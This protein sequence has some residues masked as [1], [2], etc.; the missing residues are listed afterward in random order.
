MAGKTQR[1][2][3]DFSLKFSLTDLS[4]VDDLLGD[5]DAIRFEELPQMLKNLDLKFVGAE[6]AHEF[7]D[8]GID[9]FGQNDLAR[10]TEYKFDFMGEAHLSDFGFEERLEVGIIFDEVSLFDEGEIVSGE[11]ESSDPGF[12]DDLIFEE[13]VLAEGIGKFVHTEFVSFHDIVVDLRKPEVE[14]VKSLRFE[15]R[16]FEVGVVFD[17]VGEERMHKKNLGESTKSRIR[18]EKKN[19]GRKP[20]LVNRPC[21]KT[22]LPGVISPTTERKIN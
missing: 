13:V 20:P 6:Y 15:E 22:C 2:V 17:Y 10:I 9:G 7:A 19:G 5:Q 8:K 1:V 3:R 16:V 4:G 18:T 21:Q 11:S 14:G 12:T